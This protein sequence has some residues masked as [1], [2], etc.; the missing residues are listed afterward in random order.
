MVNSHGHESNELQLIAGQAEF[1]LYLRH[2]IASFA[3]I[4]PRW[5]PAVNENPA[6]FRWKSAGLDYHPNRW[7]I[8]FASR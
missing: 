1:C 8:S 4:V 5:Y 6:L 7:K 3:V 2:R